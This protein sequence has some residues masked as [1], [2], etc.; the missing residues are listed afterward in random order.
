MTS[1]PSEGK[2]GRLVT[3]SQNQQQQHQEQLSQQLSH[4][5]TSVLTSRVDKLLREE[6]KKTV[7]QSKKIPDPVVVL[8][9]QHR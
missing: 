9:R 3:E 1:D 4:T 2:L 8:A 6:M 7:P 5:L